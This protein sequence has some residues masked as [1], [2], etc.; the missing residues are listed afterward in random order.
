MIFFIQR[1]NLY[2]GYLKGKSI[3]LEE[4]T[5]PFKFEKT[6]KLALP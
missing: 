3:D 1:K 2:G 5:I 6:S 4:V